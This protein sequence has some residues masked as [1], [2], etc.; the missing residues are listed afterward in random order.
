MAASRPGPA[1][2]PQAGAWATENA[3]LRP[4]SAA[5]WAYLPLKIA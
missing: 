1:K 4:T 3:P 5:G 2:E